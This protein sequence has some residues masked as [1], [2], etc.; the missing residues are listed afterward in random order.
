MKT[1][2]WN[3]AYVCF[4]SLFLIKFNLV[5]LSIELIEAITHA[6]WFCFNSVHQIFD[7]TYLQST[8]L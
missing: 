3:V 7:S 2:V 1:Y 4:F 6:Q 5:F 8:G